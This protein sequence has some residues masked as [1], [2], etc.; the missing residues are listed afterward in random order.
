MNFIIIRRFSV[1]IKNSNYPICKKCKSMI[2]SFYNNFSSDYSRCSKFGVRDIF[3]GKIYYEFIT[4]CRKD[5]SKCG[6][7]GKEFQ[8]ESNLLL[9]Q[10][11]HHFIKNGMIYFMGSIW[12]YIFLIPKNMVDMIPPFL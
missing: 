3:S 8:E 7:T 4:L 2:P 1:S 10:S 11:I 5:E 6:L 12:L 9:K